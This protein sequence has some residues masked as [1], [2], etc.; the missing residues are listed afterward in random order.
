MSATSSSNEH[1]QS[2]L[3]F[4]KCLII[5]DEFRVVNKQIFEVHLSKIQSGQT[6]FSLNQVL[7][8]GQHITAGAKKITC[9]LAFKNLC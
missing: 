6:G 1:L 8:L 9:S 4:E 5:F 7:N 2:G 3:I